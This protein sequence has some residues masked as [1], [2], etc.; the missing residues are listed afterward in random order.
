MKGDGEKGRVGEGGMKGRGRGGMGGRR[1]EGREGEGG[2]E[3]RR[4]GMELFK[5]N[6]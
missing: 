4:Y 6:T 3:W 2:W 1:E 5:Q